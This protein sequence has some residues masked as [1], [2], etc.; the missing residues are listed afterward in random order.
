MRTRPAWLA[1]AETTKAKLNALRGIKDVD[2]ERRLILQEN[3]EQAVTNHNY[4]GTIVDWEELL[5]AV[6]PA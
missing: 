4:P 1:Y 3:Y 5:Q 2:A 6:E